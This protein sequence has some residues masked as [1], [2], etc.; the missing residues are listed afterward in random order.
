MAS[1]RAALAVR[2][3]AAATKTTFGAPRHMSGGHQI[4]QAE[5]LGPCR[6]LRR[7]PSLCSADSAPR[8]RSRDDEVARRDRC[9]GAGLHRHGRLHAGHRRA[10]PRREDCAP[11]ARRLSGR[12]RFSSAPARPGARGSA[13]ADT[14]LGFECALTCP[15][16]CLRSRQAYPYLHI[17]S[18]QF[19]WCAPPARR[20]DPRALRPRGTAWPPADVPRARRRGGDLGFFELPP[21]ADKHG[22]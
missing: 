5:E 20:T 8:P 4:N 19:P 15:C 14:A 11:T 6:T 17:R 21:K 2:R 13:R 3:L 7:L 16:A 12:P 22:H 10:P 9:G 1:A 18:K